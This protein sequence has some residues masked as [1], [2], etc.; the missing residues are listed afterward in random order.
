MWECLS[1]EKVRLQV[2]EF[3]TQD[4]IFSSMCKVIVSILSRCLGLL[5]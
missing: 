4:S 3:R 1:I 5:I 2:K